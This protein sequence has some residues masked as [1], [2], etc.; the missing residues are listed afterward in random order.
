MNC[1]YEESISYE[2][3]CKLNEAKSNSNQWWN[4]NFMKENLNNSVS[5]V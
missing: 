5:I 2:Y 3:K 1:Q 4:N